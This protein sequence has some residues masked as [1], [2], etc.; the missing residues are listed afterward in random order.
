MSSA[1]CSRIRARVAWPFS[2]SL[3][4]RWTAVLPFMVTTI[5]KL[6]L[7]AQFY[8]CSLQEWAKQPRKSMHTPTGG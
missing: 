7:T 6:G 5:P 2:V 3:R 1:A 8:R 4:C